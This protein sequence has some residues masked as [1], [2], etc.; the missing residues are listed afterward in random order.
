MA[1]IEAQKLASL[2]KEPPWFSDTTR[3]RVC[4]Y[5]PTFL[6]EFAV[7]CSQI[8]VYKLAAQFLGKQGFSEYAI[9]RRTISTVYPIALLGLS[10]GLPRYLALSMHQNRDA[11]ANRLFS[12]TVWCVGASTA[13][14]VAVMNI[15]P[16]TFAYLAF[17][18]ATYSRLTLP[19]SLLMAGLTL[20]VTVYSYFRGHVRMRP[21]NSLQFV[22]LGVVP[23]LSFYR[24]NY[25]PASVLL[26]FGLL[27]VLVSVFG[28]LFTP[29]QKMTWNPLRESKLLLRYGLPRVPGDFALMAMLVLPAWVVAHKISVQEGGYVAF[30]ISFLS[31]IAAVFAPIG[32]VLLPKASRLIAR[33][34]GEELASHISTVL[35]LS[36]IVSA[37]LTIL[38][39]LLSGPLVRIY[40]GREFFEVSTTVR[41]VMMG[42]IPYAIYTALRSALDA[43]HFKAINTINCVIALSLLVLCTWVFSALYHPSIFALILPLPL[44][45][46]VLGFLTWWQ[47]REVH[48]DLE[49]GASS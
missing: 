46:L 43:R 28:F 14:I 48:K 33:R 2:Q 11:E 10:V 12:A 3:E 18:S 39:E 34:S 26:R 4:E 5:A 45:L 20:H 42:G 49:F 21:A 44:S 24:V 30:S 38:V 25:D 13:I 47:A 15:W 17:G 16:S 9:A 32:L 22:N 27:T 36:L 29:W 1:T 40:L 6:T 37:V 23:L 8:V 7:M 19:L 35:R 41:I 31:M